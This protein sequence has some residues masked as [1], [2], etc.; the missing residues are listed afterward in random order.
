MPSRK[1]SGLEATENNSGSAP[2]AGAD[3]DSALLNDYLATIDRGCD[4]IRNRFD[5]R[6][7]RL[8]C[9]GLRRSDS[10]KNN[11]GSA[12]GFCD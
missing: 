8:A 1:N 5:E 6:K 9:F 2:F 4:L 12:D 10:D 11:L 3:G 7:V